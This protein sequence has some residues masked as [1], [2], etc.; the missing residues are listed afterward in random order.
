MAS[1]FNAN[2]ASNT[3]PFFTSTL[4]F[5]FANTKSAFILTPIIEGIKSF[6]REKPAGLFSLSAIASM[7]I[8]P[9]ALALPLKDT[10]EAIS[11]RLLP[12]ESIYFTPFLSI[13]STV[14]FKA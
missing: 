13:F 6:L 8:L 5:V 3:E 1:I 11:D 12:E 10:S 9:P 14:P 2:L 4:A 7:V